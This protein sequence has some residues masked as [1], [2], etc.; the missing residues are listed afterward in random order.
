MSVIVM[1][2]FLRLYREQEGSEEGEARLWAVWDR[3]SN[4]RIKFT[5]GHDVIHRRLKME[6]YCGI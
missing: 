3:G 5:T 2:Y 6:P 1:T 4:K